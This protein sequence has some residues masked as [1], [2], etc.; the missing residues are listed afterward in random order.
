M[1]TFT[2]QPHGRLQE[3]VADEKGYF[4]DEGLDYVLNTHVTARSARQSLRKPSRI[5]PVMSPRFSPAPLRAMRQARAAR[6][7]TPAILAA[8][9]T[10]PSIRR[11]KSS[12]G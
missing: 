9:V 6:E 10:G 4:R 3:W 8:P 2:I 11:P 12:T 7:L 1:S 5:S